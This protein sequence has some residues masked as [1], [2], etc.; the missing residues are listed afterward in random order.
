MTSI[1]IAMASV[2]M[3]LHPTSNGLHPNS[4]GLHPNSDG[5]ELSSSDSSSDL[6]SPPKIAG[7]RNGET[8]SRPRSQSLIQSEKGET[9]MIH[10]DPRLSSSRCC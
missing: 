8:L 4:H 7:W 9:R 3:A 6:P 1:L 5:L 2:P 10:N